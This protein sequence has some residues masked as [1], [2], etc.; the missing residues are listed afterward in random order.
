MV[1]VVPEIDR[2]LLVAASKVS[3]VVPAAFFRTMLPVP[4]WIASLK[5]MTMSLTM[6]TPVAASAG[7]K[8]DTVGAVVSDGIVYVVLLP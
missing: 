1:S 4:R 6:S 7:L 8:A 2:L 5:V 3:M